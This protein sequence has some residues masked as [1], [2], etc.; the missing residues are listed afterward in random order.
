MLSKY[1]EIMMATPRTTSSPMQ[2]EQQ[3]QQYRS[4]A[5]PS[6]PHQHPCKHCAQ[7]HCQQHHSNHGAIVAH[8]HH[9]HHATAV[10]SPTSHRH[11]LNEPPRNGAAAKASE[12]ATANWYIQQTE[13][14]RQI[15]PLVRLKS[16]N[17]SRV[18]HE[19]SNCQFAIAASQFIIP[20]SQ[21]PVP[22]FGT[23]LHN[24]TDQCS[25]TIHQTSS[26]CDDAV[27]GAPTMS[28]PKIIANDRS[29]MISTNPGIDQ[30]MCKSQP[31]SI[32]LSTA[33]LIERGLSTHDCDQNPCVREC[34]ST[35]ASDCCCCSNNQITSIPGDRICSLVDWCT[36][37]AMTAP[38]Q[39]ASVFQPP[40]TCIHSSNQQM[41]A[42]QNDWSAA[43]SGPLG[44]I[45]MHIGQWASTATTPSHSSINHPATDVS[46]QQNYDKYEDGFVS[47]RIHE[48][49]ASAKPWPATAAATI[50]QIMLF[51]MVFVAFGMSGRNGAVYASDLSRNSTNITKINSEEGSKYFSDLTICFT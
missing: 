41:Q 25:F 48:R 19:R 9:H 39:L 16:T 18:S 44:P 40:T 29:Q 6:L 27:C 46:S 30:W 51:C 49:R 20:T 1:D 43:H 21:L 42:S 38:N 12:I 8:H 32:E 24:A 36:P 26:A 15:S 33:N 23:T 2:K 10:I 14:A 4:S 35:A 47:H 22:N 45:A 34:A 11:R 17:C 31:I 37:A 7:H 50:T 3:Q 13:L 28:Q 5:Q